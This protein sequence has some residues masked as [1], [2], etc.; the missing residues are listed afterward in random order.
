MRERK[1][2]T[3]SGS[4]LLL[5]ANLQVDLVTS[6]SEKKVFSP[7]ASFWNNDLRNIVIHETF[8]KMHSISQQVF[9]EQLLFA[10]NCLGPEY[11]TVNKADENLHLCGNSV[12]CDLDS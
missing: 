5:P 7:L 12:F 9:I 4:N 11:T 1:G 6:Y 3:G 2:Q 10:R 8:I